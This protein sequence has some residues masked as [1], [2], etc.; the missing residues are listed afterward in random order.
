MSEVRIKDVD[1]GDLLGR[2]PVEP[3]QT[4]MSKNITNKVVMVTGAGG[5]IGSEL[6][7]QI[8]QQMPKTLILFEVSEFALY[9]IQVELNRIAPEIEVKAILGNVLKTQ[10]LRSVILKFNVQTIYHAAAYKHVPMVEYNIGE[11]VI[12]N[13][14]GTANVAKA[15][16]DCYVE[17]FVLV[18][19]DKAVR[20]TNVMGA[21]KRMAEMYVQALTADVVGGQNT[22]VFSMVRFGN[23]LGSSGS[24]VPL[25]MEHIARSEPLPVTHPEITRYFMTIPEAAQLV[26]QAGAMAN[27]GEVFVLDMGEPVKIIDLARRMLG[28]Y[29]MNPYNIVI[30]GLRPGEKLYEE[31]LIG[32]NVSDTEHPLIFKANEAYLCYPSILSALHQI[33]KFDDQLDPGSIV[34]LMMGYVQGFRHSGEIKDHLYY[35]PSVRA[36]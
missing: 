24:V 29:G 12:N 19:T 31:L 32:D 8:V 13:F 4:L 16:L 34:E 14:L 2:Q 27:G 9:S 15:A 30:T 36:K 33:K 23:V 11:G 5:S 35:G 18:S 6:C 21:S 1:I 20:P 26:I 10:R 25:F 3:N 22:T 28:K 17:T 7:R